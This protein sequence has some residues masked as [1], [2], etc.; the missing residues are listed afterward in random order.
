LTEI[1]HLQIH[2]WLLT[3]SMLTNR[4]NDN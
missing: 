4:G 1:G 3:E 2:W